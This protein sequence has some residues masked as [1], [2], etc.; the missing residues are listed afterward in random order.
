MNNFTRYMA[1]SVFCTLTAATGAMASASDALEARYQA[2][3]NE[4][5]QATKN[6]SDPAAKREQLGKFIDHMAQGLEKAEG[7]Q[8]LDPADRT[9]LETLAG[10][11]RDYGAELNGTAGFARV[12][13]GGLNAF[14]GYIQQGMEQAPLG[15][16]IYISSGV[17]IVILILIIILT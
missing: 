7:L 12:P 16:G 10:K 5:V 8:G 6:T 14:A 13:D 1:L 3:L 11:Y 17:L 9:T 15:G 2:A 4:M